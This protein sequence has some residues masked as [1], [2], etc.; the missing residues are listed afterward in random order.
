[1]SSMFDHNID[2]N[3]WTDLPFGWCNFS[4]SIIHKFFKSSSLVWRYAS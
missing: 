4:I 1:M 3:S 2:L